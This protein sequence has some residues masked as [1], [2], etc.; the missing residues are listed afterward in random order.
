M[1][2][3]QTVELLLR[4]GGVHSK[5]LPLLSSKELALA[6]A[7]IEILDRIISFVKPRRTSST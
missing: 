7:D 5:I 3:T 1:Y 4:E 2:N 6:A